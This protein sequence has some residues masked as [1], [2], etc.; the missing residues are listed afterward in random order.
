VRAMV[1][2]STEPVGL[3]CVTEQGASYL[4]PDLSAL[5]PVPPLTDAVR[6]HIDESVAAVVAAIAADAQAAGGSST[7]KTGQSSSALDGGKGVGA[8]G[9]TRFSGIQPNPF[10]GTTMFAYELATSS[11]V[12]LVVYAASGRAVRVVENSTQSAGRHTLVWDGRDNAGRLLSPG[13]YLVRFSAGG[14][15]ATA[16]AVLMR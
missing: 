8:T 4:V 11:P 6:T 10:L 5:D 15:H 14:I 7:G 1:S 9:V 2:R 3:R 16:K 12:R 13:I